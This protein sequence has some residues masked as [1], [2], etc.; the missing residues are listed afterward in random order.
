MVFLRRRRPSILV[1]VG[2]GG[3]VFALAPMNPFLFTLPFLPCT[4]HLYRTFAISLSLPFPFSNFSGGA[5]D[6]FC[7]PSFHTRPSRMCQIHTECQFEWRF[8][9]TMRGAMLF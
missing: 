3:L 6:A 8:F 5:D 2:I 9:V 1:E 7:F 4:L